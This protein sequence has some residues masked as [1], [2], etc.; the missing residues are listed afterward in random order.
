MVYPLKPSGY[1]IRIHTTDF[2]TNQFSV[3]P[4]ECIYVFCVDLRTNSDY[5]PIQHKLTG[6]Y[7]RDEVCLLSGTDWVFIY[8]TGQ[9]WSLNQS[10]HLSCSLRTAVFT[11]RV[12][13]T[14]LPSP[15]SENCRNASP[16]RSRP[17][18]VLHAASR[19]KL[20]K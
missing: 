14:V 17:L 8:N 15:P 6:F 13:A 2:N 9:C 4:T 20:S 1:Y 10:S 12:P 11:S 18:R 19:L 5:F 16:V 7:N 3:L